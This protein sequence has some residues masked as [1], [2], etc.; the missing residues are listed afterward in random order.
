LE[1]ITE[2]HSCWGCGKEGIFLSIARSVTPLPMPKEDIRA[3]E[4][5][6]YVTPKEEVNGILQIAPHTLS[7][8][9]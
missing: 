6:N 3:V 1:D 7:N 2:V 4:T 8:N 9:K 5:M